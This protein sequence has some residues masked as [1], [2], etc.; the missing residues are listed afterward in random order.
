MNAPDIRPA[1]KPF[2][3]RAKFPY[4][5]RKSGD[6]SIT[7]ADLLTRYGNTLL[8]LEQQQLTPQTLDETHFVEV[9]QGIQAAHTVLEKAWL[10]YVRLARGKRHFYTLHSS[11]SNQPDFDED[12]SADE[13]DV[14]G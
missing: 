4:G 6:F 11:A 13:Y 9:M 12:F 3:D 7:E 2:A 1:T 8:A 10:K 14:A 5:F